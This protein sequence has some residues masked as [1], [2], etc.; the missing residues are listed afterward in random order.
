MI[1]MAVA[2]RVQEVWNAASEVRSST[3]VADRISANQVAEAAIAATASDAYAAE[4]VLSVACGFADEQIGD[5]APPVGGCTLCQR[6]L[7]A[8]QPLSAAV[9]P[10]TLT[11][12]S[13]SQE[14]S[15]WRIAP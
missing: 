6:S 3:L 8:V 11:V 14:R 5:S 1:T 10:A 13:K 4:T 7:S 9:A 15:I 12:A 2:S